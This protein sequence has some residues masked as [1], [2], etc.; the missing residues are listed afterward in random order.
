MLQERVCESL[1]SF[2]TQNGATTA[3]PG[4]N[5]QH[6]EAMKLAYRA[7]ILLSPETIPEPLN[8]FLSKKASAVARKVF[9]VFLA[10]S[11]GSFYH[12]YR[13]LECLLRCYPAEVFE[14]LVADGSL[15][16][17]LT[18]L[19]CYVGFPPVCE[20]LVMLVA[21]T[22]LPRTSPVFLASVKQRWAFLEEINA[23]N[24]FYRIA[25]VMV[26][27]ESACSCASY[28]SA[29]Q[30]STAAAQLLQD[31]VEKLSLEDTGELCLLPI[32]QS[33][34]FLELLI[35]NMVKADGEVGVRRSC[36]RILAFLLRRAAESEIV[37][38]VANGNNGPP[39]ASY[40]PNRLFGLRDR[41]IGAVRARVP[42]ITHALLLF[43]DPAAHASDSAEGEQAIKYSSYQ[44]KRPFSA[45]R[46]F[47][48]EVLVLCV[49]SEE[50]V[51]ALIPV[52]L[53]KKLIAWSLKYAHNN[54]YHALFYR[55]VFAVL[56]Q[57]QEAPQRIIFQ[58]AKF[59]SYIIDNF[60]PY[61]AEAEGDAPSELRMRRVAA[62]GLIMNC[63]NAI[64]LQLSCQ[65]PTTFLST[66]LNGHPKWSEF[67]LQL[68]AATDVQMK[69][70]MGIKVTAMDLKA[71]GGAREG[72]PNALAML[73]SEAKPSEESMDV[74]ARFARSLGF[75]EEGEWSLTAPQRGSDR[76]LLDE[77]L[78]ADQIV[79]EE[80]YSGGSRLS[81]LAEDSELSDLLIAAKSQ[82]DL[83]GISPP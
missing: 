67:I 40:V 79:W 57:G 36:A 75:Y 82:A 66:F 81:Y 77:A 31:L 80:G 83:A 27:A 42:D 59:A 18:N 15:A 76:A 11:G 64:R 54:V 58:K 16:E 74:N 50:T 72:G 43:D 34:A 24:L 7:V 29:D 38:F 5:E 23:W 49:E 10:D 14:G 70:G 22:P 20:M 25:V 9:D 13:V 56:R 30:H 46:L 2:I 48:V 12:A 68:T 63:A 6:G 61:G 60:I 44:V 8:A 37:C 1:V 39:T 21:L 28:V 62:R 26:E 33:A 73:I 45:L 52:D 35:E 53:W 32:G 47:V 17:R 65:A 71:M 69:F 3:R 51:A 55:M 4:P 41:I 78:Q 19:L